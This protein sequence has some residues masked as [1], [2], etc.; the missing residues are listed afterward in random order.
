MQMNQRICPKKGTCT[1]EFALKSIKSYNHFSAHDNTD[2]LKRLQS[3]PAA[4]VF[5]Q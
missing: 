2:R 1:S 3:T 5:P 4:G